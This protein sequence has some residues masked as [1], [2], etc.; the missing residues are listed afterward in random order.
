MDVEGAKTQISMTLE[1]ASPG[2]GFGD[3]VTGQATK[4]AAQFINAASRTVSQSVT[5]AERAATDRQTHHEGRAD[6]VAAV[7][8]NMSD[9]VADSIANAESALTVANAMVTMNARPVFDGDQAA[10]VSLLDTILSRT[11]AAE[12]PSK[13]RDLASR[14]SGLG[15]FLFTE[16]G[17]ELLALHQVPSDVVKALDTYAL[18]AAENSS[19]PKRRQAFEDSKRLGKMRGSL[20]AVKTGAYVAQQL[21]TQLHSTAGYSY[22]KAELTRMRRNAA[23]DR[24]HSQ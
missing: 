24:G 2:L 18:Q 8:K 21:L 20:D 10:S 5:A 14:D 4:A 1:A 17:K 7:S 3:G 23:L 13:L 12:M 16:A 6:N 9:T 19:S 11:P 22:E 15:G